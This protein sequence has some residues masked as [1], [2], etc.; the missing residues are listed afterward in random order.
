[1]TA[2]RLRVSDFQQYGDE[3]TLCMHENGDKRRTFGLHFHAA[4]AISEY[5]EKAGLTSGPYFGRALGVAAART[6]RVRKI[7]SIDANP[8]SRWAWFHV[9]TTAA[10]DAGSRVSGACARTAENAMKEAS[11][12]TA[13]GRRI[14]T[15][16]AYHGGCSEARACGWLSSAAERQGSSAHS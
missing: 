12:A 6:V 14:M 15:V 16:I 5:I 10:R 2:C 4:Q 11:A 8:A 13:A 3:A 7:D 1:M 9:R